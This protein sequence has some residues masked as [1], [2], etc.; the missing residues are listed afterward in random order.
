MKSHIKIY[1]L[2]AMKFLDKISTTISKESLIYLDP[3]YYEQGQRLYD[4]FY[5]KD[6]HRDIAARIAKLK[7]PWLVSY[8]DAPAIRELYSQFKQTS[9]SLL[10]SAAKSYKGSEVIIFSKQL[11]VAENFENGMMSMTG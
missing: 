2:D 1:N 3:P 5:T 8:D 9:C 7:T 11:R 4:N 10:Y 6:Q